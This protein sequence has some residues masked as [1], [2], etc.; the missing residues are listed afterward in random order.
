MDKREE[1]INTLY[2]YLIENLKAF[3]TVFFRLGK[4]SYAKRC[5]EMIEDMK[6]LKKGGKR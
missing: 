6:G 1:F 4:L 5:D 3:K 2:D